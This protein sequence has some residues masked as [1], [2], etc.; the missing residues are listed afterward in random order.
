M[1]LRHQYD[2]RDH[3]DLISLKYINESNEWLMGQMEEEIENDELVFEDEDLT[4]NVVSDAMGVEEDIY[5]T[6]SRKENV[7]STLGPLSSSSKSKKK[8]KS[9]IP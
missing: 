8:R 5:N 9:I 7:P 6:R 1:E 2:A 3:N 4:W